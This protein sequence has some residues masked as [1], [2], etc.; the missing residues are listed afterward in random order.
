MT[1]EVAIL[2]TAAVAL[3]ADSAVSIAPDFDKIYSTVDKLFQL[4]ETAPVGIMTND[5]AEFLGMPWE[6]IVKVYRQER[7]GV[8]FERLVDYRDDFLSFVEEHSS[9]FPKSTQS[10]YIG[11]LV[12]LHLKRLLE[13]VESAID[14][15][16][17]REEGVDEERFL[18][19]VHAVMERDYAQI[20][21][22][23]R[24]AGWDRQ[25]VAK[26]RKR[27]SR[28]MTQA[29]RDVFADL[30]LTTRTSRLI[31]RLLIELLTRSAMG[32]LRSGLVFA[33]FGEKEYMPHLCSVDVEIMVENRLRIRNDKNRETAIS[34]KQNAA[35]VPFAQ[36]EMVHTFLNGIHPDMGRH[37]SKGVRQLFTQLNDHLLESAEKHDSSLRESLESFLPE[38]FNLLI[39]ELHKDWSKQR[40][41]HWHPIIGNVS[42]LP[43]DE[44]AA[45][46]E[47]LVNLTKFRRR[48][49]QERETVGGPIDV[50]VITKG[51]GFVWIKRKHYFDPA[52]NPRIIAKYGEPER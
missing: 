11:A 32:P 51:D 27:L 4:S 21:S 19:F 48:I 22:C 9:M 8:T 35:I 30:P 28:A 45:M 20:T 49:S 38:Q 29:K 37:I 39:D 44:L 33:G 46:A 47:A 2:N 10:Y 12:R 41:L 14:R 26:I 7:K 1:A 24:L 5:S 36:Q 13:Q 31:S 17:G 18:E 6:A 42:V 50:A 25:F 43:K 16:A 40:E 15:A 34:A 3:A 52:L 23:D